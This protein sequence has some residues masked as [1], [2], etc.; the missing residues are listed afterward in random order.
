[1]SESLCINLHYL[2]K[3]LDISFSLMPR[4]WSDG[5]RENMLGL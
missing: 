4:I 3:N 5:I 1:M 2:L